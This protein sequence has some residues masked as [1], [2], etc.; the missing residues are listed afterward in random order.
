MKTSD[1]DYELPEEKIAYRPLKDRQS[2]KLLVLRRQNQSLEDRHFYDLP[3]LLHPGDVLVFNNTK[4]IPGRIF[5]RRESGAE[6]EVL[7]LERLSGNKWSC[8]A[9]KPKEG[10]LLTFEEGLTGSLSLETG[11]KWTVEFSRE[12]DSYLSTYGM[13]PL[14]PYIKREADEA[15]K[16]TYQTVYA[17]SEGAAAAP[18]AGLHFTQ[19]L[20]A[21]I[22]SRGVL[23]AE[24]TL[25]VGLGTFLP[26]KDEDIS[27]HRMH[28]EYIEIPT[29]TEELINQAKNE[30][31]RVVAVGTTVVRTLESMANAAG[32]LSSGTQRT[33]LFITPGYEF[34][35]V[36]AMITNFHQPRSTLLMLVSAFSEREYIMEAYEHALRSGYRFLSYGDAMFII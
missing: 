11:G 29:Q 28:S 10:L 35:V 7:L 24:V 8:L 33:E 6:T 13:M 14:P 2:S 12:V 4:V 22:K 5:G 18:T 17:S 3:E 23:T 36:D 34:K 9:K 26:V 32:R 27:A 25:H 19:G 21:D 20:I 31:R 30:G 15:D 16:K 1:F